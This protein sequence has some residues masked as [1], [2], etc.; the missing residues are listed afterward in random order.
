MV[1]N[2]DYGKPISLHQVLALLPS[3]VA[4]T[5]ALGAVNVWR[6]AQHLLQL[7]PYLA[8]WRRETWWSNQQ[9]WVNVISTNIFF[10]DLDLFYDSEVGL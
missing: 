8:R 7:S 2:G 5:C 10:G 1:I 4:F 6:W 9:W 3:L